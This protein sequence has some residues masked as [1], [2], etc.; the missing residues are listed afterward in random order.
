MSGVFFG[1]LPVIVP[2][3]F[4]RIQETRRRG[5]A[6]PVRLGYFGDARPEKGFGELSDVVQ[7]LASRRVHKIQ[8]FRISARLERE[9]ETIADGQII[10][11]DHRQQ[12]MQRME[13]RVRLAKLKR[14]MQ[15]VT[16]PR[17]LENLQPV[18]LQAQANFNVP[19]GVALTRATRYKL[20][21]QDDLG[22]RLFLNGLSSAEYL[23]QFSTVDI[24]VLSYSHPLYG[25]GSSG[26][27][28]E[29]VT[30][31][32]PV[33]VTDS[34]W[35]GRTLR[36]NAV[37]LDHLVSVLNLHGVPLA[38]R[39]AWGVENAG[40]WWS[41]PYRRFTHIGVFAR[42][43]EPSVFDQVKL[44]FG[45]L[46]TN[47]QRV[48]RSRLLCGRSGTAAA[49]VTIP[50]SARLCR[51]AISRLDSRLSG[52]NWS[53]RVYG[54]DQDSM[55]GP[56]QAAGV[57]IDSGAELADGVAEIA[58]HLD[59]YAETAGRLSRLWS[60]HHTPQ[61]AVEMIVARDAEIAQSA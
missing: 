20:Q 15:E 3:S 45:F 25:A 17:K 55:D 14:E 41:L 49:V 2:P 27:F 54:L 4:A 21:A 6:E 33:I 53:L 23:D 16:A 19:N 1:A 60:E 9:F 46:L 35:G 56:L 8:V 7:Q 30:A 57:I 52:D 58:R 11:T 29:S 5:G 18:S 38:T 24:S 47:G 12:R 32:L 51:I 10:S 36:T 44:E 26:V 48:T 39:F 43:D 34:T 22:V 13:R 42:F 40:C 28:S 37:Y 31:G 59:H 61:S 50:L